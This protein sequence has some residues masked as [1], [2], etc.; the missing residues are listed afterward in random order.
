MNGNW[1][2]WGTAAGNPKGNTP[3]DYINAWRHVHDI[4]AAQGA[5]NATW[6]WCPNIVS[7]TESTLASVYPGD[8]YVDWT[9]MDGYNWGTNPN[10]PGGT[11]QSFASVFTNTYNQI[12]T[13]A[14]TKPLL[15]G[16]TASSEYG[17][18]K[19]SWITDALTNQLPNNFPKIRGI[20]WFNWN[21]DGE[22]WVIETSTTA[23]SAFKSA[24]AN[25]IYTTNSYGQLSQSPIPPPG[26]TAPAG[27]ANG[28]GKVDGLDYYIWLSHYGQTVGGGSSVGD[29]NGDGRV[30]GL[31]YYIWLSNYGK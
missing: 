9:C 15:I 27:D 29:F 13:M 25:M 19:A 6:V 22:D 17:G 8:A 4:F 16:E 31:D 24:I 3:Q 5:N 11:W 18:S 21:A 2:D 10:H 20:L 28:D 7:A 14:P 1:F 26:N 30:D 23:Q 12:I